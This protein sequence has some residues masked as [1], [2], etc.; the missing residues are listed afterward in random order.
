MNGQSPQ[1]TSIGETL[2]LFESL[3]TPRGKMSRR[4]GVET[5]T[6]RN[7][8]HMQAAWQLS[9][10]LKAGKTTRQTGHKAGRLSSTQRRKVGNAIC[11]HLLASLREQVV[12]EE[13]TA[14]MSA[15]LSPG[16]IQH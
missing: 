8:L 6:S 15:A 3:Q 13:Q 2:P 14:G 16:P 7:D 10:A 5:L 9:K 1:Q 11:E 12:S 4:N